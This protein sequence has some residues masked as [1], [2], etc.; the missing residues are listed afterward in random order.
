LCA[1]AA[2]GNLA[3][4]E[5]LAKEDIDLNCGDYDSRTALHLAAAEGKNKK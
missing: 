3:K 2:T 1:A 4:L 5:Q